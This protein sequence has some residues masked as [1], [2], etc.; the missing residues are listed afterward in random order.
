[1]QARRTQAA[2]GLPNVSRHQD[3]H[4]LLVLFVL[5]YI[6]VLLSLSTARYVEL[7]TGDWDIGTFQQALWSTSHGHPLYEA[8]DYQQSG[9]SSLFE[10]HPSFV[11]VALV[12]VYTLAASP[13][14]LFA[15]QALIVGLAAFPLYWIAL[16]VTGSEKKS[17]LSAGV[18][19]VSPLL[20]SANLADFHLESFLPL[21]LFTIFLLWKRGRYWWGAA[22]AFLSFA[23]IE[24]TPFL[25]GALALYFLYPALGEL[26]KSL[27]Q[28]VR[29]GRRPPEGWI[30][31]TVSIVRR[32][33]VPRTTRA[34]MILLLASVAAFGLL[35]LMQ[36]DPS[37][38]LL[39]PLMPAANP[40]V[41]FVGGDLHLQ[42]S[43]IVIGVSQRVGYWVLAYALVAFLPFRALRTQILV[44]PW[45]AYT[46]LSSL[47]YT[48]LGL[49]YGFLPV[50]PLLVGFVYGVSDLDISLPEFALRMHPST[51]RTRP[52]MRGHTTSDIPASHARWDLWARHPG[53]LS[54]ALVAMVIL[55]VGLS[56]LDPLMQ[57]HQQ[58]SGYQVSYLPPSQFAEVEMLASHIPSGA[59]VVASD[60]LF[61][62][63]ANDVNAY[64]FFPTGTDALHHFPFNVSHLPTYV[65]ISSNEVNGVPAWLLVLLGNA[66]AY[67]L[68][69]EV[70]GV[71][72]GTIELY[73][74]ASTQPLSSLYEPSAGRDASVDSTGR[75]GG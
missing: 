6:V 25:V 11:V 44:L 2:E 18:Y 34:T 21:E 49:Q 73:Q 67:D 62:L 53:L 47:E 28:G 52:R 13:I 7:A 40:P 51:I 24:V 23:T 64:S 8:D 16:D 30:R 39:T 38:V 32:W 17:L 31:D 72:K 46:F 60:D 58:G 68:I 61:P 15:L 29:A 10:I 3:L 4:P 63:V 75:I 33:L 42:P 71:P 55:E 36:D 65:L 27:V 69:G 48:K 35:R 9:A 22:V 66:S 5:V 14:T 41:P 59:V 57:N 50:V 20:I 74:V 26:Y 56:P 70:T 43:H 12:P 54:W 1:M 45:L 19:L 37:V